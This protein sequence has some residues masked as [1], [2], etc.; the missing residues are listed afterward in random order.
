[1]SSRVQKLTCPACHRLSVQASWYVNTG[2]EADVSCLSPSVQASW[3]VI[4]GAEADVS[5]L[6]PSVS[7]RAGMSSRVQ[8]L[9]CPACHCL[10][11][12][13]SWYVNTGAEADVSC[14]S[15][16]V[17]PGELVCHHGCRS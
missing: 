6:S 4:T 7:R 3:Y 13:A 17:C 5:C 8:K 15:P 11:V 9:T 16:S 10:S 14:L 12:Q 1:M 2:A